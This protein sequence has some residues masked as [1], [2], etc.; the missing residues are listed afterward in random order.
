MRG[1][2]QP[3][4]EY[5]RTLFGDVPLW[6][7]EP[8]IDVI[9]RLACQSLRCSCDVRFLAEGTFNKV[10]SIDCSK[11]EYVFRVALPVAPEVKTLS[12]VATM[13]FIRKTTSIPV[14]E[15]ITYD[16][17]FNNKLGF[18]WILMERV[19]CRPLEERWSELS[20][21]KKGLLIQKLVQ[22]MSELSHLEL[23]EIGS[24]FEHHSD[25]RTNESKPVVEHAIGEAV[26]PAFFMGDHVQQEMYRGPYSTGAEYVSAHMKFLLHD[27]QA[28]CASDNEYRREDGEAASVIYEKLHLVFLKLFP[29]TSRESTRIC[30]QDLSASNILIDESGDLTGVIDW[31]CTITAPCWQACK[32]PQFLNGGDSDDVPELPSEEALQDEDAVEYYDDDMYHYEQTQ[33]RRFF[34]EEMGRVDPLWIQTYNEGA[35]RRDV[36]VAMESFYDGTRVKLVKR[37]LDCVLEGR[38]PKVTLFEAVMDPQALGD[39]WA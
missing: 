32:L 26:L 19:H 34:F 38:L 15:V 3:E 37:W 18:E 2:V 14:P 35:M 17:N 33:L 25:S 36:M 8:S 5:K 16:A 6:K 10:Y 7:S 29:G 12:D 39:D 21:L 9:E 24:I 1:M 13:S 22:F 28:W 20:W 31:E 23:N 30:H 4:L 27:I 11:G